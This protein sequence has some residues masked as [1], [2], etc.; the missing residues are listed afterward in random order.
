MKGKRD[1]VEENSSDLFYLRL[2]EEVKMGDGKGARRMR[3]KGP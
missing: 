2:N 1:V 3:R